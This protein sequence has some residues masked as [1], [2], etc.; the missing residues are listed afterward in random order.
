[1]VPR[2]MTLVNICICCYVQHIAATCRH[3]TVAFV[4]KY[5]RARSACCLTHTTRPTAHIPPAHGTP[6]HA[7]TCHL[8]HLPHLH[9]LP[10]AHHTHTL[11]FPPSTSTTTTSSPCHTYCLAA[12][13]S[14]THTF[15]LPAH[16]HTHTTPYLH[17]QICPLS[18]ALDTL[19]PSPH[20]HTHTPHTLPTHAHPA[21]PPAPPPGGL[22]PPAFPL[23]L[24]PLQDATYLYPLPTTHIHTPHTHPAHLDLLP[25]PT[26]PHTRWLPLPHTHYIHIPP[27]AH[28]HGLHTLGL[29]DTLQAAH[30]P[31]HTLHTVLPHLPGCHPDTHTH[32]LP[33]PRSS[34]PLPPS[35]TGPGHLRDPSRLRTRRATWL[36]FPHPSGCSDMPD[37][38][39]AGTMGMAFQADGQT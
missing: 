23:N 5:S 32:L 16:T 6:P 27:L 20:T 3:G 35:H 7:T 2:G 9:T 21:T 10:P 1:L 29:L 4:T 34:T 28:T 24:P 19:P 17:A 22:P 26:S 14:C 37:G 18:P 38:T 15:T 8:P 36:P 33:P 25:H 30:I 31:L 12:L 39:S 13:I 11:H